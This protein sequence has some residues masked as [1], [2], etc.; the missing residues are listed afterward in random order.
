MRAHPW[1]ICQ[2]I[3][4]K[5]EVNK[6]EKSVLLELSKVHIIL[7]ISDYSKIKTPNR[8]RI[9]LLGKLIAEWTKLG[10]YMVSRR[11]K[12]DITNTLFSQTSIYDYESP[13]SLDC[14][15]VSEK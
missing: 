7:A 5:T 12:N 1:K 4:L 14:L 15:G 13:C 8:A 11:E 3:I 9:G 6:L 10:W 2:L